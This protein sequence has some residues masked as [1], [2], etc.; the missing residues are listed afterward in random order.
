MSQCRILSR[1]LVV[2]ALVGTVLTL[3]ASPASAQDLNVVVFENVE[4]TGVSPAWQVRVTV[5]SLGGCTPESGLGG[6]GYV[7]GWLRPGNQ[8][9]ATLN[10]GVCDYR[11]TA[12][13]RS[14]TSEVCEAELAWGEDATTGYMDSLHSDDAGFASRV[15][16]RH[17]TVTSNGDEVPICAAA[18]AITFEIDPEE[19]VEDLPRHARDD[20]LEARVR[21]AAEVTD[22]EVRVQP[23]DDT[24][25]ERGCN[26]VLGFT[27]Q[28]GEDGAVKRN[29]EGIPS[30][31]ICKFKVSIVNNPAPFEVASKPLPFSTVGGS[32][33]VDL[34]DLVNLAP[35]RIAIIQDVVGTAPANS[36]VSYEIRRT[37]AGIDVLPPTIAPT[38]GQGLYQLPGGGWRMSLTRGRYTVHSD[39]TPNFGAGATYHAAARSLTSSTVEGCSVTVI[40]RHVPS[41]CSVAGGDTQTLTWRKSRPFDHFD[42]EFDITCGGATT[43]PSVPGDLPPTPPGATTGGDSTVSV[44]AATNEVRIVARELDNGKIEFALQQQQL[45]ES[46]SDRLLPQRRL[47]PTTAVTGQWLQSSV[48]EVSVAESA[49]YFAADLDVRIIARRLQNGNVEFALQQ[50]RDDGTWGSRLLPTRRFFPDD[51]PVGR[52]MRSSALTLNGG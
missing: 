3:T 29:L 37:C 1:A 34:D 2:L 36:G 9:G 38:G 44:E 39:R 13:A 51:A 23:D 49:A 31:T 4:E 15:S 27:M 14:K 11:I 6:E 47:F 33:T 22:F 10:S 12:D 46:W 25:R 21:R 48:L 43:S 41:G 17:K 8:G 19:I 20:N 40:I 5:V 7:S 42:F 28:A 35:T 32:R 26:V 52:W 18:I 24:K 45:D 50:R 16:V 30:G